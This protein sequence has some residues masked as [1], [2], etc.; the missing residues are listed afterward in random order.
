M[1]AV[2][3]LIYVIISAIILAFL[4]KGSFENWLFKFVIVTFLPIIGWFMPSVWPKRFLKHDP[5]FFENYMQQQSND[6]SAHFS[7]VQTKV[8]RTKELDVVSIE[9]ALLVSDF[10]TRRQVMIDVLK[11]DAMQYI[12]VLKTAVTNDDT[13]TSHYAVTAVIEVKRDLTNLLQKLAVEFA[14]SPHDM[15]IVTSYATVVK[16][17]IRSGFLDAKSLRQYQAKY[18]EL[19]D[20]MI[21]AN[22]ATEQTYIDKIQME[23]TLQNLADAEAT[24]KQFKAQF[25]LSEE[26]YLQTMSIYFIARAYDKFE[27]ELAALMASPITLSHRALTTVRYWNGVKQ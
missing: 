4:S 18:V 19:L 2:L 20:H 1:I 11:Q 14:N 16:E 5:L 9:E 15:K 25:P 10:S 24:A 21:E 17:Y 22:C 6:I 27:Q 13:E 3:F 7:A 26:S 8:Q 12:D 23:L